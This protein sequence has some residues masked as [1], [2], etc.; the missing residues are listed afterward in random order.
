M[1]APQGVRAHEPNGQ[2]MMSTAAI[3]QS[4]IASSKYLSGRR[5]LTLPR[6]LSFL[7]DSAMPAATSSRGGERFPSQARHPRQD[8]SPPLEEVGRRHGAYPAK[9]ERRRGG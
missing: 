8:R 6:L 9:N 3:V 7:Q 1:K 4:M 5:A 2:R